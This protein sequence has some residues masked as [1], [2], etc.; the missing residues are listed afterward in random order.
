L[1]P[2][3]GF[4]G[5]QTRN[6]G[7]E[8][9]KYRVPVV[10]SHPGLESLNWSSTKKKKKKKQHEFFLLSV[11]AAHVAASPSSWTRVDHVIK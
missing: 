6:L 7:L 4:K 5:V 2:K 8:L 11:A 3:P 1:N 10:N 9:W